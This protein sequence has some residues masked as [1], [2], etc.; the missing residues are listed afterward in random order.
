MSKSRSIVVHIDGNAESY[1]VTPRVEIRFERDMKMA[2]SE[3]KKNED[4][5]RLAWMAAQQSGGTT[6]AFDPWIDRVD[7]IDWVAADE[8]DVPLV[9]SPPSGGSLPSP[10]SQD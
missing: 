10:S 9:E 8:D 6:D 3:L 4:L 7:G 2:L 5:Y 1:P